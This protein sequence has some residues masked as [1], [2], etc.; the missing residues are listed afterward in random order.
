[1]DFFRSQR[2]DEGL[3]RLGRERA[4]LLRREVEDERAV[5]GDEPVEQ[6]EAGETAGKIRQFTARDEDQLAAGPLEGLQGFDGWPVDRAVMGQGAVVIGG[7]TDNVHWDSPTLNAAA[8]AAVPAREPME[9][10]MDNLV[11]VPR[12]PIA[13]VMLPHI[14]G[15]LSREPL[16]FVEV[17]PTPVERRLGLRRMTGQGAVP[18]R[19]LRQ[20]SGGREGDGGAEA[21]Q[22]EGLEHGT[23]LQWDKSWVRT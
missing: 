9:P 6:V 11:L 2:L 4:L 12:I 5:F 8:A 13:V 10:R 16:A 22:S 23:F 21:D 3:R 20:G 1:M 19:I 18:R 14:A 17:V 15:P 7:E